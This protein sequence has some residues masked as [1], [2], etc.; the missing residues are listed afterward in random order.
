MYL[1]NSYLKIILTIKTYLKMKDEKKLF[2]FED[3]F[4]EKPDLHIE[5]NPDMESLRKVYNSPREYKSI[6]NLKSYDLNSTMNDL[7]IINNIIDGKKELIKNSICMSQVEQ[8]IKNQP[9]GIGD[10]LV[11]NGYANLFYINV[12]EDIFVIVLH[13]LPHTKKWS[14]R[15]YIYPESNSWYSGRRIF[16]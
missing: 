14:I 1:E 15:T 13:L 4:F 8:L 9:K 10:K 2:I 5:E 3:F 6:D 12:E 11:N 7:S 16:Y